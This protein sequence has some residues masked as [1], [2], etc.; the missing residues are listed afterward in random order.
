[1]KTAVHYYAD[2]NA[3]NNNDSLF[4]RK[5]DLATDG[6]QRQHVSSLKSLS[7]V[8]NRKTIVNFILAMKTESNLSDNHRINYL[9]CL[10]ILSQFHS[11][12]NK[13]YKEMSREDILLFLDSF[14]KSESIDPLHKWI[15]TYNLYRTLLS[16]FFKWLYFPIPQM[17]DQVL[18]YLYRK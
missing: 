5:I 6:L 13:T 7:S 18:R 9:S 4:D 1:V 14:R 10:C 16:Y 11:T 12:T 2:A 17:L 8:D 15:G 3:D